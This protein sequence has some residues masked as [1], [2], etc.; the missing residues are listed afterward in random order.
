MTKYQSL[1]RISKTAKMVYQQTTNNSVAES[2]HLVA[3]EQIN[4]ICN[5]VSL[6]D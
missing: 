3:A 1:C 5:V 4:D 2:G 6:S